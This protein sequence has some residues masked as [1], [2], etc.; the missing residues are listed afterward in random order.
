VPSK[1]VV[2]RLKRDL[3]IWL[4]TAG[5]DGRPHV[6]H[7]WF[8]WDGKSFLIY[9]VP[10]QKV[11]DIQANPEVVLHLN[12][13]PVGDDVV[14]IDGTA[15]VD[16]RLP[17]A[18]KVPAYVRKYRDQIKGFDWTPKVFSDKYHFAIRIRPT[19]FH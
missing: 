17:P 12:T 1:H 15:K 2:T 3:V 11:R 19:R 5:R 4:A 14:R 8:W 10:G 18:Y 7:V 13:D 6:V 9:S 16:S